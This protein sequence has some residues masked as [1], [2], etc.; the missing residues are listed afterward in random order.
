MKRVVLLAVMIGGGAFAASP[1][2]QTQVDAG[3]QIFETAC[4][5]S[6]CHGSGGAGGQAPK[7]VERDLTLDLIRETVLNGRAGTPMPPFKDVLFP[8]MQVDVMAFVLSIATKGRLPTEVV[9]AAAPVSAAPLPPSTTPVAVGD[10]SGTPAV[11]AAIFFDPTKLDSCRACHSYGKNGGPVGPDLADLKTTPVEILFSI[12]RPRAFSPRYRAVVLA[13][14]DG[15]QLEGIKRDETPAV[16]R[17][18]D[19]SVVPPVAR[20]IL[21][22]DVSKATL[23]ANAGIYDHTKLKYTRQDLLDLA[24]FLGKAN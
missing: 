3:K 8:D 18:F 23:I 5:A 12:A 9:V 20:T 15:G 10:E 21:K 1:A 17:L 13:F 14:K 19:V 24:A 7:L 2:V 16:I 6:T 4:A 22:S 11:G